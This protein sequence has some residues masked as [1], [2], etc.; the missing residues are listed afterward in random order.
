[1]DIS[2]LEGNICRRTYSWIPRATTFWNE[3]IGSFLNASLQLNLKSSK[4]YLTRV[5][6]DWR[7]CFYCVLFLNWKQRK[8][9]RWTESLSW[10]YMHWSS[11]WLNKSGNKWFF[12]TCKLWD[13]SIFWRYISPAELWQHWGPWDSCFGLL[14]SSVQCW[15]KVRDFPFRIG[16]CLLLAFSQE[17][18]KDYCLTLLWRLPA[19]MTD[20]VTQNIDTAGIP[21]PEEHYFCII[22]SCKDQ[23]TL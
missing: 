12:Q 16:Y 20:E 7:S 10:C 11:Y 19:D 3:T 23:W 6:Q 8:K 13:L 22:Y 17:V 4:G 5:F 14:C 18:F 2:Q 1:M 9:K 15:T 21:F